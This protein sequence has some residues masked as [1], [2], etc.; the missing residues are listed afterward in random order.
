MSYSYDQV[1]E[2]HVSK[3]NKLKEGVKILPLLPL[4]NLYY[5]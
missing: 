3:L 2:D 1:N 4:Q 5:N